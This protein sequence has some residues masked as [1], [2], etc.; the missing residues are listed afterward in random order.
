MSSQ[1]QS[2]IDATALRQSSH[3]DAYSGAPQPAGTADPASSPQMACQQALAQGISRARAAGIWQP[4]WPQPLLS[5]TQRG[6]AA[7]TAHLQRWEIR[8]NP[9]LLADNRQA[10]IEEVIP[11]ELCHLLVFKRHGKTAPH[12]R[13]WQA[14]MQQLFALP[15]KATHQMDIR[16]VIGEQFIYHCGC[17]EHPLS[18]RRHNN[19]RRGKSRYLCRHC[20]NELKKHQ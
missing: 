18:L 11:H 5:F 14:L 13:E 15:G 10:F 4:H 8:L 20:G 7:G 19:V 16:K 2:S 12:G 9:V 17:R 3:H 1:P 6:K